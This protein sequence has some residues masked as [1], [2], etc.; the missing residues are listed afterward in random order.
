MSEDDRR[1]NLDQ[2]VR[3]CYGV[4]LSADRLIE[5]EA[6]VERTVWDRPPDYTHEHRV[7]FLRLRV[8]THLLIVSARNL[9]R[10]LERLDAPAGT[11]IRVPADMAAH[12]KTLR[13]CFEHW[14][15][16][17]HAAS[18]AGIK[19]KAYREFVANYPDV[20]PGSYRFGQ[21]G[22]FAGGVEVAE[23]RA[24]VE[25]LNAQL[26]ALEGTDFVWRGWDFR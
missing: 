7:P 24:A 8:D 1:E 19:G 25:R 26:L 2:A 9:L 16:R 22:T 12:I 5:A 18:G 14:D 23:L 11:E 13:D 3:W 17:E 21:G 6:A 15:E 4:M 20:E 10:A